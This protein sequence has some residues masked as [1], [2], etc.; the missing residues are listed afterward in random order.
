MFNTMGQELSYKQG[1]GKM[2][3]YKRVMTVMIFEPNSD[4]NT[5]LPACSAPYLP[6]SWTYK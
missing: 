6:I 3:E 2:D 4:T 5:H 1:G